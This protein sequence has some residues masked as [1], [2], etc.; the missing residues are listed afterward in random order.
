MTTPLPNHVGEQRDKAHL[1]VPW[2]SACEA[3]ATL[4]PQLTCWPEGTE[5]SPALTTA[6]PG[7]GPSQHRGCHEQLDSGQQML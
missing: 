5:V 4:T 6:A 3:G 1:Q 7:A 2:G